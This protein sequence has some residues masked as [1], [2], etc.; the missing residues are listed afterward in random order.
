MPWVVLLDA[1]RRVTSSEPWAPALAGNSHG[2]PG[3]GR[4]RVRDDTEGTS[5]NLKWEVE[6]QPV[7]T[8]L[9]LEAH[10][11]GDFPDDSEQGDCSLG[12][13]A[14]MVWRDYITSSCP[15]PPITCRLCRIY[16][17][18][19]LFLRSCDKTRAS[20]WRHFGMWLSSCLDR[21]IGLCWL[22]CWWKTASAAHWRW[23]RFLLSSNNNNK[24]VFTFSQLWKQNKAE[25][26][27]FLV[28][29]SDMLFNIAF[30]DDNWLWRGIPGVFS[31]WRCLLDPSWE[32]QAFTDVHVTIDEATLMIWLKLYMPHQEVFA[33]HRWNEREILLHSFFFFW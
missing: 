20:V 25:Q 14:S 21:R 6:I 30:G 19:W 5:C 13:A 27:C 32:L 9:L 8:G 33:R 10:G 31:P 2:A 4:V 18:N 28:L 15:P 7:G 23:M 12:S 22:G 11:A 17:H 16:A 29:T 24:K 3:T 26:E 1:R